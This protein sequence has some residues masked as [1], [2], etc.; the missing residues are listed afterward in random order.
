MRPMM[1]KSW[2]S[3]QRLFD[4]QL[5]FANVLAFAG[6]NRE[7]FA[8]FIFEDTLPFPSRVLEDAVGRIPDVK[9]QA[10]LAQAIPEGVDF[11]VVQPLDHPMDVLGGRQ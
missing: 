11:G 8:V 9:G 1:R 10:V 6:V 7:D 5:A 2:A 3:K 4:D